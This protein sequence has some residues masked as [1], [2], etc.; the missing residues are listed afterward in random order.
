MF[1]LNVLCDK[2]ECYKGKLDALFTG[3]ANL[4][5]IHEYCWYL[6]EKLANNS[7]QMRMDS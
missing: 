3:G 1:E 7:R 4:L 2:Q 5:R 6:N